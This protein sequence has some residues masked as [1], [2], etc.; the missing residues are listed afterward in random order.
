MA[1]LVD[2]FNVLLKSSVN[3]VLKDITTRR[4]DDTPPPR[5][6]KDA[7]KN[8]ARLR[9]QIDSALDQEDRTTAEIA[10]MTRQIAEWDRQADAALQSGDDNTARQ[11]VRKIQRAQQRRA[12]L[13]ADLDQH[14]RST[15]ELIRHVNEYEAVI[16]EARQQNASDSQQAPVDNTDNDTESLSE[17][18]RKV[19][20]NATD[21]HPPA[22]SIR[23]ATP[24]ENEER[25]D[26]QAIEDDL[27]RR[28]NRLSL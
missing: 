7:D 21:N 22:P 2:K 27:A 24:A 19:R 3:N 8:L 10:E 28:R 5:P 20:N 9:Q 23:V 15:S 25:L 17:R 4:S 16:A 13:E 26:E 14:Q 6:G 1:R 12:M 18:L 11:L